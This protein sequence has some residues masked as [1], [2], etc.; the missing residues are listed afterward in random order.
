MNAK[1][2]PSLL[3]SH[4]SCLIVID[5]QE[6]LVP[7]ISDPLKLRR[8]IRFLMDAAQ[9]FSI[10][11]LVTEQ[12]P[13]GLGKTVSELAEHPAITARMEKT[14]FSAAEVLGESDLLK[15][16]NAETRRPQLIL[17]GIEAHI[18]VQQTA[19][20]LLQK[21]H[22]VY[23]P[24]DAVSSRVPQDAAMALD[25]LRSAGVIVTSCESIVFEWCETAGTDVFRQLSR[26]VRDRA[27]TADELI[28]P[29]QR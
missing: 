24:C 28:H 14:R 25:R 22:M 26:L 21:G 12:Y 19:L 20:E 5:V 11:V 29:E 15:S 3:T 9:L 1:L 16:N 17:A 8:N 27:S 18:C 2:I 23:L 4:A 6:R 13:K 7:V 10:P